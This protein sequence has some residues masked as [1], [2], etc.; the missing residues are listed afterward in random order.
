MGKE[1]INNWITKRVQE[2]TMEYQDI[3]NLRTELI[4]SIEKVEINN[5]LVYTLVNQ[6]CELK[7]DTII[8]RNRQK[9]EKDKSGIALWTTNLILSIVTLFYA[10]FNGTSMLAQNHSYIVFFL[11]YLL[12]LAG[13][14]FIMFIPLICGLLS[15]D[16]LCKKPVWVRRVLFIVIAIVASSILA[17][18][19]LA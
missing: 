1:H 3:C 13:A 18:N 2:P 12:L 19:L 8:A 17:G 4:S 10:Q 14:I 7:R 6:I 16:L 11:E 9:E 15:G 5:D